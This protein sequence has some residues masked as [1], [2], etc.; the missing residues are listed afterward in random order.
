MSL[1]EI[2][3]IHPLPA[4]GLWVSMKILLLYKPNDAVEDPEEIAMPLGLRYIAAYLKNKKY[5][6]VLENLK[7]R[8]K[9][10]I[11]GLIQKENPDIVGF[12]IYTFNRFSTLETARLAKQ[13]NPK[14]KTVLGGPYAHIMY[15]QIL[16]NFDF[17]DFIVRGEGEETMLKLVQEIE[18]ASGNGGKDDLEDVEGIAFV[19]RKDGNAKPI[20]HLT[21]VRDAQKNLDKFPNPS[22]YF[23]YNFMIT[24]RGCPGRCVF[25]STPGLWGQNTRF[26]SAKN[27]V[28][29]IEMLNKKHSISCFTILDDTFTLDKERTVDICKE[30]ISRNLR[31]IW[32]CRARVN[33]IDDEMLGWMKK[34]GCRMI[35]Y[36]VESGSQKIL[37]NLKKFTAVSQIKEAS[38][39]TR[40]YGMHLLFFL[41]IG[42]P[43]EN[44]DT[45]NET[46]KII[47]ECRPHNIATA[48]MHMEPGT[49]LY[50]LAKEK[51]Y[52]TDRIWLE[53]K[54]PM[55]EKT[56]YYYE[57]DAEKIKQFR[58]KINDFFSGHKREY[59]YTHEELENFL[60]AYP[61]DAFLLGCMGEYYYLSKA[62][63][64][65]AE[66]FEK[67]LAA[68][69]N[70]PRIMTFL[71]SAY[72]K[73][74]SPKIKEAV[75]LFTGALKIDPEYMLAYNHLGLAYTK[76]GE[77]EAA[78]QL[79]WKSL[80]LDK[81]YAP[82]YVNLGM[83]FGLMGNKEAEI[84]C[85]T[86]AIRLG[87]A[88]RERLAGKIEKLKLG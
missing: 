75:K 24:S 51:R 56:L 29:E 57:N 40:K 44:D 17:I 8:T 69:P 13:I 77:F 68:V 43:G 36:G 86:A 74:K 61:D 19:K 73:I 83:M 32:D 6:A 23:R 47:E 48:T 58:N 14:I 27:V 9:E 63:E 21:K 28:D 4:Y 30:I 67:A 62:Y 16:E 49:E 15:K 22:K 54:N 38:A 79:F 88:D 70:Y 11:T 45:V 41:I 71:G 76:L 80:S 37:N 87:H 52:F 35:S 25:C 85:Y 65:A 72:T 1:N 59:A 20:V 5:D 46:I 39:L 50:E 3:F 81:K 60:K 42:S 66:Y 18:A 12:T 10:Q 82:T 33:C 84:D 64:N 53:D 31:I 78:R 55:P 7:G 26:R 34:A 2:L